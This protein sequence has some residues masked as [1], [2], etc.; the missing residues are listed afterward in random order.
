MKVRTD[1]LRKVV[2][3]LRESPPPE[4]FTMRVFGQGCGTPAC[5]LGHYAARRDLQ[6]TFKLSP[7]GLLRGGDGTRLYDA[8]GAATEHFQLSGDDVAIEL[9][10]AHGCDDAATAEGA[11]DYIEAFCDRVEA[12]S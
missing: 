6:R 7:H 3:A 1:R 4:S 2:R 10:G 5:A 8:Y 9:F 12:Q 11:A